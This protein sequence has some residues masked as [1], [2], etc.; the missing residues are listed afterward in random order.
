MVP[1]ISQLST[2]VLRYKEFKKKKKFSSFKGKQTKVPLITED[3]E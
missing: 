1:S 2:A 3:N